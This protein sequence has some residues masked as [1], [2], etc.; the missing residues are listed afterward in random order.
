MST[1]STVTRF[2]LA[3][4]PLRSIRSIPVSSPILSVVEELSCNVCFYRNIGWDL[5]ESLF[6][7]R[8]IS[9]AKP[10]TCEKLVS[11]IPRS[12]KLVTEHYKRKQLLTAETQFR[13]VSFPF[14]LLLEHSMDCFDIF[15]ASAPRYKSCDK[16]KP[17]L[18]F[19]WIPFRSFIQFW[20]SSF[21]MGSLRF[22]EKFWTWY[23]YALNS[24]KLCWQ[25]VI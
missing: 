25:L 23:E 24:E 14:C 16:N 19:R 8:Y 15:F 7:S 3:Q 18:T 4:R 9:I 10:N 21:K 17:L 6:E 11:M 5:L 20:K 22:R 13:Q 2:R 12:W 1:S